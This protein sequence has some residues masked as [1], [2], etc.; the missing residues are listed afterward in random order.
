LITPTDAKQLRTEPVAK[1]RVA[2]GQVRTFRA[3][4]FNAV[5]GRGDSLDEV[6]SFVARAVARSSYRRVDGVLRLDSPLA[7]GVIVDRAALDAHRLLEEHGT[8]AIGLCASEAC[9]W[10]FL[11]PTHRRRWCIM[12]VCG[13]RAKA[14]RFADRQRTY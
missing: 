8:D 5:T 2:L 3:A 12:A 11:D 9:G 13:N 7:A 14:R 4:L 6:Q 1:Q 10:V